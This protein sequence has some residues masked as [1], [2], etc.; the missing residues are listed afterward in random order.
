MFTKTRSVSESRTC[1]G[2]QNPLSSPVNFC[3]I[4]I[5]LLSLFFS[6]SMSLCLLL[7][8]ITIALSNKKRFIVTCG[9]NAKYSIK[10]RKDKAL[11]RHKPYVPSPAFIPLLIHSFQQQLNTYH[12]SVSFPVT[13]TQRRV[14]QVRT[15]LQSLEYRLVAT[16]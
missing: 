4:R 11:D 16:P 14:I 8:E 6:L 7:H 5:I 3:K 13:E 9:K 15:C 1:M 2:R 12:L 10:Q